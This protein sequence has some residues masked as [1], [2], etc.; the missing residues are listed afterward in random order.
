MVLVMECNNVIRNKVIPHVFVICDTITGTSCQDVFTSPHLT[1]PIRS[2]SIV[3]ASPYF[4]VRYFT[5]ER[6]IYIIM[7]VG[8]LVN[9]W[10][11]LLCFVYRTVLILV[12]QWYI[13]ILL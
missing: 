13:D 9:S 12:A 8:N 7:L 2:V 6:F 10:P 3:P 4:L 5:V 11:L 1:V